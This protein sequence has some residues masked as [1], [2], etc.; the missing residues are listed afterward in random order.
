MRRNLI[1][2]ISV[3]PLALCLAGA[4]W[5]GPH[6]G[7]GGKGRPHPQPAQAFGPERGQG[8]DGL[9]DSV[10]RVERDT[11]GRVLSAERVPYDGRSVNRIKVVD[12]AGRVRVIM[13]DPDDRQPSPPA[14]ARD[15]DN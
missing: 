9:S 8:R 3:L 14:P 13:D 5:A 4:A 2:A 12:R 6:G 15:D 10:R 11:Q 7:P 1:A